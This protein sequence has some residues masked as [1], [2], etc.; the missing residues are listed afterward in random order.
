[1]SI[2]GDSVNCDCLANQKIT[3]AS[4]AEPI[5]AA[6]GGCSNLKT[7]KLEGISLGIEAAEAIAQKIA[8]CPSLENCLWADCFK[9]RMLEEIPPVRVTTF[10]SFRTFMTSRGHPIPQPYYTSRRALKKVAPES[11]FWTYRTMH[12][13]Q[14][15]RGES[16]RCWR[17]RRC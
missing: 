4:D 7:L 6:I 15:V 11:K 3:S 9:G 2:V 5:S 16:S 12:L 17:R 14:M 1:M 8:K 10:D 13:G